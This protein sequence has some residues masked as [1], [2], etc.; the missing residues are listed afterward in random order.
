MTFPRAGRSGPPSLVLFGQ[1]SIPDAFASTGHAFRCDNT[2][3]S[4]HFAG[5]AEL[6]DAQD[7][8]S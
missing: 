4:T 3:T 1:R 6:A 7:L 5:V 8:K 2:K